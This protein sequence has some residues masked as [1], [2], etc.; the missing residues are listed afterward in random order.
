MKRGQL[1]ILLLAV[2]AVGLIAFSG[3]GGGDDEKGGGSST[4]ESGDAPPAGAMRISFPYSP[5]KKPLME[6]LIQRFNASRT[7]VAGKAVFVEGRSEDSGVTEQRIAQGRDKPVAWSPASS[8][9]GRLLNFEADQPLVPDENPSL[10]RTPLV[11]AM[12]EPMAKALGYPRKPLGF[13]DILKLARSKAGWGDYGHPEYGA[14]KLVHTNPDA[15][16]SGLSAVAAE[17]YAATGKKEGL[18]PED[19]TGKARAE[20]RAIERSIVHYGNNTLFIADQMRKGGL[21][22]A[23]AVAMEEATLLDFNLDKRRGSLPKLVAIYPKEGT[24]VSDSPFVVLDADWVTPELRE[25]A[26]AFQ[27]YLAEQITPELAAREGFRPADLEAAP[28]API[29]PENGVDPEQPE[30]ELELPESRV[31]ALL[32]RTWRE[33]RKPANVLLVLDTSGSMN[34]ESRLENAKQGLNVFFGEVAP[35]D[36]VGLTIFSDLITPLVPVGPFREN[37]RELKSRVKGLIAEGGTAF[38]D[39]TAEG[40]AAVRG[41]AGRDDRIN[42]VVL[43][44]DGNDTDSERTLSSV[45]EELE[46][47]DDSATQVRV[48][49]IAYSVASAKARKALEEIA[50]ASGGK[51]YPGDPEN[52]ETVYRSI[53]SFF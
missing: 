17:Y 38:Y 51:T 23:S 4:R 21:G 35:Q 36:R 37:E 32:K 3:G 16:T 9:W 26:L 52:I 53:S 42:A 45:V 2:L 18:R 39:A 30:R 22:Y 48:F 31:L 40:Y 1:A 27:K 29:T 20:V 46:R 7:E 28:V 19:I 15:S 41:L 10:V 25:G 43:L 12:W 5:E 50:E 49:T 33:D 47:Q 8:L 34:N 24:F 44:T 6:P 11:I 13:E 14:F